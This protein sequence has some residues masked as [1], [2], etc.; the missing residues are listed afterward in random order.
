MSKIAQQIAELTYKKSL[1]DL[2]TNFAD[3]AEVFAKDADD[4]LK[5]EFSSLVQDALLAMV[6]KLENDVPLETEP[7]KAAFQPDE[8]E[9]LKQLVDQ[10][11][12]RTRAHAPKPAAEIPPEQK[13]AR[14][15]KTQF[16]LANQHLAGQQVKAKIE[17]EDLVGKVVGLDAPHVI[18]QLPQGGAVGVPLENI[19]QI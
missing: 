18:V 19:T 2:L 7:E 5:K 3:N 9:I 15:D 1:I 14:Q 12:N 11:R 10:V 4:K 17:G 8:I 16:A 6:E 13:A